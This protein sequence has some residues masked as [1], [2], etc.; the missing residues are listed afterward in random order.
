M[1][2]RLGI[3]LLIALIM[4]AIA[5]AAYFMQNQTLALPNQFSSAAFRFDYPDDW[6]YQI[7]QPNILFL[8]SGELLQ[9][10]SGASMT[11]QRSIRLT[12]EAESLEAALNIFLERGPLRS[13]RAWQIVE[14]MK[15][16]EL[17]QR[18]ALRL[19]LAGSERDDDSLMRS[20]V[21]V[22][23]ADNGIYYILAMTAPLEQWDNAALNFGA[24]LNSFVILE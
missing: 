4:T 20:E 13:D 11:I 6:K 2:M 10:Q 16:A 22:T 18:P 7:P 15:Q 3:F 9:T 24:I 8:A 19:A 1:K 12:A 14:E 21:F 23:S 17:N 5:A